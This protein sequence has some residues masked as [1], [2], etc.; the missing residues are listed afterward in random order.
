MATPE[1]YH[2]G[3]LRRVL[4]QAALE[5][6]DESGLECCTLREVTRRAGVSHAAPYH[7]FADRSALIAAVATENLRLLA[8]S[9]RRAGR[10]A[11]GGGDARVTALGVAYVRFAAEHPARF[12][13]LLRPEQRAGEGDNLRAG[14]LAIEATFREAV[15]AGVEDGTLAVNDVEAATIAVWSAFHG[16]AGLR[17]D[18]PL[19]TRTRPATAERLAR[20]V[21]A[22]LRE[23]L[24]PAAA[25]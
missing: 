19:A 10:R 23:G 17:L 21:A 8:D 12:R 15:N 1:R 25:E 7:H 20:G 9:L 22:S 6:I 14:G 5:L 13:M 2:H 18:G 24:R 3:D 4:I 16:L 11:R